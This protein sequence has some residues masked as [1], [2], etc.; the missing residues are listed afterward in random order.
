MTC[1][2]AFKIAADQSAGAGVR[3]KFDAN[4]LT[5][6]KVRL[7]FRPSA[8]ASMPS[9]GGALLYNDLEFRC[10]NLCL[11][12]TEED[13]NHLRSLFDS[14]PAAIC[15]IHRDSMRPGYSSC[16]GM[17]IVG[18]KAPL[19]ATIRMICDKLAEVHQR[20]LPGLVSITIELP[21]INRRALEAHRDRVP[22]MEAEFGVRITLEK[23]MMGFI[24]TVSG[25]PES[26]ET[27][28]RDVGVVMLW[29]N[30]LLNTEASS[31]QQGVEIEEVVCHEH[32]PNTAWLSF[33]N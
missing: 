23:S 8:M 19:L 12:V 24:V 7:R 26:I 30:R 25:T 5:L 14:T 29:G 22:M 3:E 20:L 9:Q 4:T 18:R 21:Y 31:D 6:L 10:F 11:L 32:I 16:I 13:L 1:N 27:W 2:H 33:M 15:A 28:T 17:N